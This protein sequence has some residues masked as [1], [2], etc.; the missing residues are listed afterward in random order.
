MANCGSPH[1]LPGLAKASSGIGKKK[2]STVSEPPRAAHRLFGAQSKLNGT[3]PQIKRA[4]QARKLGTT[5]LK[6]E[7][8]ERLTFAVSR[9][10]GEAI[11][12][13]SSGL[14]GLPSSLTA[15]DTHSAVPVWCVHQDPFTGVLL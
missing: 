7:L 5:G 13:M 6:A 8:V 11:G 4:L 12:Q 3:V 10:G 9:N 2:L 1:D 15:P 14:I